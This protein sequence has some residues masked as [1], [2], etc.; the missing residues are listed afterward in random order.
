M[1]HLQQRLISATATHPRRR[2]HKVFHPAPFPPLNQCLVS[3][4][5]ASPMR[6]LGQAFHSV[7]PQLL[8]HQR[9]PLRT[10]SRTRR[11]RRGT[12]WLRLRMRRRRQQGGG[13]RRRKRTGTRTR[14]STTCCPRWA[15]RSTPWI[16]VA[17]SQS[18]RA[19]CKLLWTV[20]SHPR[21]CRGACCATRCNDVQRYA[22][23]CISHKFIH[24]FIYS[25]I[26]HSFN[27][28]TTR[29]K[30]HDLAA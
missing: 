28:C 21:K 23:Q 13:R 9:F 19:T 10:R 30:T 8:L 20:C 16:C 11:V 17:C 5:L 14:S 15:L 1:G 24:S 27:A 6:R 7:P 26:D 12:K 18:A 29:L 25:L 22:M 3:V 2:P 4:P